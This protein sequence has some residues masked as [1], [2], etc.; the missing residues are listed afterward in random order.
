M[1]LPPSVMSGMAARDYGDE[2]VDA[3]VVRDAE[4]FAA[5][6]DEFAF[7]IFGG[8]EGHAVH[9]AVRACRISL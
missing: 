3:D 9:E 5:G 6:V 2:R 1:M 4:A 8:R 7:E